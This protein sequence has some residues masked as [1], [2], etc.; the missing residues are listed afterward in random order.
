MTE[1]SIRTW[2]TPPATLW[3]HWPLLA[4]G[5]ALA[6]PT[7]V[8]LAQELW[9]TEAGAHGPIVLATGL[10][11]VWRK[12]EAARAV[13]TPGGGQ[14]AAM[15]GGALLLYLFGRVAGVLGIEAFA[16]YAAGV[17]MLYVR[18]GAAVLRLLWFPLLYLLF[19]VPPPDLLVAALTQP[20]KVAIAAVAAELLGAFGYPVIHAGVTLQVGQYELLV[21]AACSGVN[22]L[23]SLSALGLLYA[24]LLHGVSPRYMAVLLLFAIVP[25]AVVA[26]LVRVLL[27][28]LITYHWGDA[29][30]Q[31]YLHDFAGLTML[32]VTA[33]GVFAADRV[34]TLMRNARG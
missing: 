32:I 8:R 28:V 11:L 33:S 3:R 1:L 25:M 27:L 31:G 30:A 22:S 29:A 10:W 20:L 6:V 14:A 16:L 12:R 34:L 5:L 19:L 18:G 26:N 21:A 15:L 13:A 9:T 2:E 23:V 7:L 24:Y 4:G 17:A